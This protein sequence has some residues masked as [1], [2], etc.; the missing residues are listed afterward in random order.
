MDKRA[1]ETMW[2]LRLRNWKPFVVANDSHG[3][4]VYRKVT[5]KAANVLR[6]LF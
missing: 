1:P 3:N 2:N 5:E 4:T 6:T